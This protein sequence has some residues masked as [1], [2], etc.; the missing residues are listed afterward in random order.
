MKI[1]KKQWQQSRTLSSASDAV[2]CTPS[3]VTTRTSYSELVES[4]TN[5]DVAPLPLDINVVRLEILQQIEEAD[6]RIQ[7]YLENAPEEQH[8]IDVNLNIVQ[9]GISQLAQL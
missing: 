2:P 3:A 7:W 4:L 5:V 1:S 8:W 9:M 6:E